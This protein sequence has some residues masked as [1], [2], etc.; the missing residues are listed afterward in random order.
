MGIDTTRRAVDR[1]VIVPPYY[2]YNIKMVGLRTIIDLC[3]RSILPLCPI[4]G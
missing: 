3:T 4:V 2:H 1:G